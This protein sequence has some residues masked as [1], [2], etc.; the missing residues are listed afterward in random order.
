MNATAMA[1]KHVLV[2]VSQIRNKLLVA[3]FPFLYYDYEVA[4]KLKR[5]YPVTPNN[6]DYPV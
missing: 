5:S 1:N 4:A 2:C 6:A 3:I